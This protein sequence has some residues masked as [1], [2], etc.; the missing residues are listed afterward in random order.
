MQLQ[1]N[2]SVRN[3]LLH[4][5]V[6]VEQDLCKAAN[7]VNPS[8]HLIIGRRIIPRHWGAFIH[9]LVSLAKDIRICE[10]AGHLGQERV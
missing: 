5:F 9:Q 7:I 8:I 3:T 1:S 2:S 6:T 4:T 10:Q